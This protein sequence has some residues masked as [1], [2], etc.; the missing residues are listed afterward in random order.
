VDLD[1]TRLSLRSKGTGK[2][3][4]DRPAKSSHRVALRRGKYRYSDDVDRRDF[5]FMFPMIYVDLLAL[6][7]FYRGFNIYWEISPVL[8]WR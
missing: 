8:T 5:K 4:S 6:A 7:T 3:D 1:G 2:Q